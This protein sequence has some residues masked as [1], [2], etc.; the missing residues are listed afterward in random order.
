MPRYVGWW[1]GRE[2]DQWLMMDGDR[3][4]GV[5]ARH[6]G[7]R[8]SPFSCTYVCVLTRHSKNIRLQMGRCPVRSIFPDALE[9]LA[10][11]QDKFRWATVELK[12]NRYCLLT[13]PLQFHV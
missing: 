5:A 1:A 10:R 9:A 4:R 13:V 8:P 3:S 11:N 2:G 6:M 12:G 7:R